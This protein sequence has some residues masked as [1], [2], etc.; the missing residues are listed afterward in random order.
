MKQLLIADER[1]EELQITRNSLKFDLADGR[2][3]IVPLSWCPRLSKAEQSRRAN[4]KI[5][6]R[7]FVARWPDLDEDVEISGL[8]AGNADPSVRGVRTVAH[9][10]ILSYRNCIGMDG[11]DLRQSREKK[12]RTRAKAKNRG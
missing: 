11:T 7:G 12:L 2:A 9:C 8:L 3:L 6:G 1:I 10:D 5:V 4:F